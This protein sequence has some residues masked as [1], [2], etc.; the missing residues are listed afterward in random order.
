MSVVLARGDRRFS[1]ETDDYPPDITRHTKKSSKEKKSYSSSR[2]VDGPSTTIAEPYPRGSL[3]GGLLNPL[4]RAI[5]ETTVAVVR[6]PGDLLSGVRPGERAGLSDRG[7]NSRSR[8]LRDSDEESDSEE[9]TDSEEESDDDDDDSPTRRF[10]KKAERDMAVAHRRAEED[11][12]AAHGLFR[13]SGEDSDHDPIRALQRKTERDMATAHRK[14]ERDL[15]AFHN[16]AAAD[17]R[18]LLGSFGA[19]R[20]ER[21]ARFEERRAERRSRRDERRSGRGRF[22]QG[23]EEEKPKKSKKHR[24]DK[25]SAE[26]I[27]TGRFR[28]VLCYWDGQR[29]VF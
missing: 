1:G 11:L 18:A 27:P 19:R 22:G 15:E 23:F 8:G 9:Y 12:R 5:H 29:E 26:D 6:A 20:A 21:H 3:I 28:L 24:K 14:A 25:E 2:S 17:R 4:H 16:K 7:P 10:E 13:S